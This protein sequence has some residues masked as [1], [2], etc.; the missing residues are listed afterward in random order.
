M[1]II[2]VVIY[3]SVLTSIYGTLLFSNVHFPSIFMFKPE[4]EYIK[5]ILEEQT[6]GK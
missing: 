5:Y 6:V 2:L 3:F 4:A 1:L